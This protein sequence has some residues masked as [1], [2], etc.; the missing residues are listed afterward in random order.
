M[1]LRNGYLAM[2]ACQPEGRRY[3]IVSRKQGGNLLRAT[4][5]AGAGAKD[6][7]RVFVK[8]LAYCIFQT[9]LG[10]CGIAWGEPSDASAP[11]AVA[12]FQLPEES[13]AMTEARIAR[14]CSARTS[15]APPPQIAG[16][17]ERIRKHLS[18]E[19]QDF[20]DVIIDW[21]CVDAFSRQVYEVARKVPAG[22]TTTYGEIAKELGQPGS[23]RAVGQA[24]GS[25]P[26]PLLVPCH[27]VVAAGGK[28]GGF[29]A[30]GGR[31]TKAKMLAIEGAMPVQLE[32]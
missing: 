19:T 6:V 23:A 3:K 28:P 12:F 13:P 2:R 4:G 24:M 18:G 5:G 14:K 20:R 31:K 1:E 7:A 26:V 9:P 11:I 21:D 15:S 10:A 22:R 30:H 27:R 32:F 16:L 17:I 29:S 8:Q 25:N